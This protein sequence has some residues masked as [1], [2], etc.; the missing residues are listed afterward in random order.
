VHKLDTFT[1]QNR[2]VQSTMRATIWQLYSEL[3]AYRCAPT[4]RR[5][6]DL[7]AEFDRVFT[8][9]TGFITLD[10]LLARL[11]AS[12]TAQGPKFRCM[13]T[14]PSDRHPPTE[15]GKCRLGPRFTTDGSD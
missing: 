12:G 2:A 13:P 7:E 15:V 11:H 14:A 10:R 3:T 8:G 4:A 1:D 5:R 6:A 9:K